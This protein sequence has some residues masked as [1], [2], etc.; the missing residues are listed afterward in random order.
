MSQK[1]ISLPDSMPH[2]SSA[3]REILTAAP[4]NEAPESLT[5]NVGE[6]IITMDNF[7]SGVRMNMLECATEM[8]T[9]Y[10]MVVSGGTYMG[11]HTHA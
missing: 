8:E 11:L 5:T 3:M 4:Y 10:G 1:Y 9:A 7:Y 6:Q 2:F